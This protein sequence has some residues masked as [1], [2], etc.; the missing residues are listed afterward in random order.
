MQF[1]LNLIYSF[2]V[3]IVHVYFHVLYN[4]KSEVND[5]VHTDFDI[6]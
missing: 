3:K 6:K 5:K 4:I 2:Y 1:V